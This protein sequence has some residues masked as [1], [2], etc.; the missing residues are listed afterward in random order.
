MAPT[1]NYG[2]CVTSGPFADLIVLFEDGYTLPHCLT[3]AF[4]EEGF[5]GYSSSDV[6]PTAIEAILDL[7]DFES[8]YEAV[9]NGPHDTIPNMVR[10]GFWILTAPNR[11]TFNQPSTNR[12]LTRFQ[13]LCS[14]SIMQIWTGCDGYGNREIFDLD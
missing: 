9:E 3:R 2:R 6:Q 1:L 7:N 8:F 13:I 12:M 5:H 14:F 4:T 10:G 11:R